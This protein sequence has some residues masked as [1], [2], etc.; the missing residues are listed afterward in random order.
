MSDSADRTHPAT[1]HRRRQ[2][3]EQGNVARSQDLGSAVVLLCGVATLTYFGAGLAGYLTTMLRDQLGGKAWLTIHASDVTSHMA[4]LTYGLA[5]TLLPILALLMVAGAITQ[6]AQSGFLLFPERSV[7]DAQRINPAQGFARLFSLDNV[8]RTLLGL[9]KL[10]AVAALTAWCTLDNQQSITAAAG[11]ELSQLGSSLVNVVLWTCLKIGGLLLSLGI[12]D[13]G[14]QWWRHERS[15]RMTTQEI[16]EE[17]R[18]LQ[19]DP[20]TA[21][22]R[23]GLRQQLSSGA[24]PTEAVSRVE[25]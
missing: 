25:V 14:Y 5:A 8:M 24:T 17:L 4:S 12:A 22:R 11:G 2:A 1:P 3:R 10:A 16:R 21:A 9:I 6:L 7:F 23:K 19:G 20:Q 15:L 13:Y 18:S